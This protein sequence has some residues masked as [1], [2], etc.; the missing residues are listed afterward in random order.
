MSCS[1]SHSAQR[2]DATLK[3]EA[4]SEFQLENLL[5]QLRAAIANFPDKRRGA[6]KTYSMQDAAL[7]AFSVFFTQSPSFLAHQSA[8]EKARGESNAQTLFGLKKIPTDNHLRN[9]LDPVAPEFLNPVFDF[10]WQTLHSGG[11]LEPYRSVN[12]TV[13]IAL[14]GTQYHSSKTIHCDKCNSKEH[15]NGTKTY[16]HTVVTPVIVAPGNPMV[17][18]MEPSFVVPQD[19]TDKQDCEN[20][21]TKRWLGR[22]A[23]RCRELGV[24]LLGDDLYCH[25]PQ[26]QQVL[27]EDLNFLF[28]CKPDSHKTLYEWVADF[29][30]LKTLDTFVVERRRGKKREIDTYRFVNQVPLRDSDDALMVN[31]C[32]LVTT[33]PEGKVLYHNAWATNHEISQDNV[34]QMAAA[35]RTRWK[36]ENE[37][38]NTLK[39]KGYHLTHNYGHGQEHLSSLLCAM[40]ILA[41]LFH[42][43]LEL[44]DQRYRKVRQALPRRDTFFEHIRA[45]TLY[46]L[47]ESWDAL[48]IFMMQGLKLDP[49]DTS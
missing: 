48:M 29:E 24:T 36:V 8:M 6:N 33:T 38:N 47:F 13:L 7:G 35:G 43:L 31:W 10:V 20:A 46:M 11:F 44:A 49:A 22:F 30:R 27:D 19:G 42:C 4:L 40:I 34:V 21:A 3:K 1:S 18:P 25:Q 41:F 16:S 45:L 32:E 5:G 23:S 2:D 14:D 26:C 28:V 12:D 37:N 39:T 15:K 17:F 9:L